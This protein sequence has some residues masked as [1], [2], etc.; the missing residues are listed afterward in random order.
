MTPYRPSER[1]IHYG[2]DDDPQEVALRRWVSDSRWSSGAIGR[3]AV[4]RSQEDHPKPVS[5]GLPV[6]VVDVVV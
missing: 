6:G 3:A 1:L 4:N 2:A 5:S